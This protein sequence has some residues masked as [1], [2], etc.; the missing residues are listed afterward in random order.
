[1]G[2]F[3]HRSLHVESK[4]AFRRTSSLFT[5]PPPPRITRARRTIAAGAVSDKIH[6]G[7]VL[8]GR[9]MK[10][11][12]VKERWPL[13]FEVVGLEIAQRERKAMVDAD[14]R[15]SILGQ[16]LDQPFGEVP[17]VI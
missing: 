3:R 6:T 15:R 4:H 16:P 2:G 11:E 14:Q 17:L 5:Q 1:M 9:P 12:I 7:V 8:V 10:L 13:R